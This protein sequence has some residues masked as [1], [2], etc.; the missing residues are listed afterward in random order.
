VRA[1]TLDLG[2]GLEYTPELEE[3]LQSDFSQHEVMEIIPENFFQGKRRGFL[4][5]LGRSGLPVVIHGVDLSLGSADRFKTRHL[6]EL[7]RVAEQVNSVV[8]SEHLSMTEAGGVEIGQLCPLPWTQEAC[9]TACR[10][11]ERVLKATDKPF[12][13]E[14]VANRFIVPGAEMSEPQFINQILR[15]TGCQLLLDVQNVY[16]NS[17]N[18]RFDPY[19]WLSRID[20]HRV[21]GV[22]LAGGFYD[23]DGF[24]QDG[25]SE[26]VMTPVWEL[27]DFV[28][29]K[30]VPPV[31]IL[32]RTA[33]VPS[34]DILQEEVLAAR[35]I[36]SARSRR[37][38]TLSKTDSRLE[39]C[40]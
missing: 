2:V 28:C 9:D 4:S 35:R 14:N 29:R 1:T 18:F 37:E 12:M 27:Y 24:L 6:E 40:L 26:P 25:H 17:V 39:V 11:I 10:N 38:V 7:L 16:V 31:T 30:I 20:L 5:A 19:E 21:L 8:L 22:H 36:R 13:I 32:E 33:N 34:L 23:T 15:R 3:A